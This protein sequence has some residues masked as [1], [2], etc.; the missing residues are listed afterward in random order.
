MMEEYILETGKRI[1]AVRHHFKMLQKDFADALGVS[2]S[3]LSDME[4]GAIKPRYEL[5]INM[6]LKYRVNMNY[7]ILGTGKMFLDEEENSLPIEIKPENQYFA[8]YLLDYINRSKLVKSFLENQLQIYLIEKR[9]LLVKE[10][11][12]MKKWEKQEKEI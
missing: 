8:K 10:I 6:A 5:I 7:L 11:E 2:N 1:Q 4:N 12:S 9:D 3:S